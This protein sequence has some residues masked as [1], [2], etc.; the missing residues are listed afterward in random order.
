MSRLIA[1]LLLAA[2]AGCAKPAAPVAVFRDTTTQIYSNAV[3]DP[4]RLQGDWRQVG[5]FAGG[6]GGCEGG[7]VSFGAPQNGRMAVSADLCLDGARQRFRGEA[8]IAV[9]GRF[10]LAGAEGAL[11]EPWW[12]LWADHDNRSLV[13]GTPSGRMGF[14]LDRGRMPGDRITAARE[15]LDWNGYALSRLRMF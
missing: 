5:A 1:A 9:P 6:A 8:A 4:A 14:V 2:L 7:Q 11:A 3:L 15:I 12:V 13:I 10:V